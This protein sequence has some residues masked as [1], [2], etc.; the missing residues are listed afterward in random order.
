MIMTRRI[1]VFFRAQPFLF[2]LMVCTLLLSGCGAARYSA[3]YNGFNAAYANSSNRQMLLNLAR[4]DQHDP[5]YFLQFGQIS[6][7]YQVSSSLNGV[8]SNILP[9][10]A[11]SHIPVVTEV[12]TIG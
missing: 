6:V 10:Q 4:L 5:T 9:T 12:G 8:V 11:T 3:D 7:Q 2:P 1:S